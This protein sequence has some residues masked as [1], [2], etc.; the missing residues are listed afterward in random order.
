M[1]KIENQNFKERLGVNAFEEENIMKFRNN[2]KN[3]KLRNIYHRLIHN[4]FFT[5][6]RMKKYKMKNDDRC[7]R[8]G[9]K[10]TSR[11]LLWEC[12]HVQNI[13]NIYNNLMIT[14]NFRNEIV[15]N[16]EKVFTP[17][18]TLAPCMIKIKMI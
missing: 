14:L 3:P 17:G 4:D 10:E 18:Q 12:T 2:C 8:C 5:H 7:P 13:W 1:K 6:V 16:F 15:D 11:H 9:I